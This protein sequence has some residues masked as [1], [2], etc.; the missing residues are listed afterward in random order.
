MTLFKKLN[1]E[2]NTIVMVTHD[3]EIANIAQKTIRIKDG[4]IW[5]SS[6]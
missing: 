3:Q 6:N 5:T 2:G 1:K 4:E